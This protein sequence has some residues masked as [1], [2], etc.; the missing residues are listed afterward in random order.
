M[1]ETQR[2]EVAVLHAILLEVTFTGSIDAATRDK[3]LDALKIARRLRKLA[4]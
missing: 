4:K 2:A 1:T 3:L